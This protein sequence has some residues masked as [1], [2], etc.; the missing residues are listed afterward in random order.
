MLYRIKVK[1]IVLGNAPLFLIFTSSTGRFIFPFL[2]Q[3]AKSFVVWLLYCTLVQ[4]LHVLYENLISYSAEPLCCGLG[5]PWCWKEIMLKSILVEVN[6]WSFRTDGSG[7]QTLSSV[8]ANIGQG[9]VD[10][11]PTAPFM[12]K[13][14]RHSSTMFGH[15][16]VCN[17]GPWNLIGNSNK[18]FHWCVLS[19]GTFVIYERCSHFWLFH[20]SLLSFY[21][22][23]IHF[24]VYCYLRNRALRV[25]DESH[26][27]SLC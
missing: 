27:S 15:K 18:K 20:F 24:Y 11:K 14:L 13:F 19:K 2:S 6:H 10:L 16:L 7:R 12:L 4:L 26:W 3:T 21:G 9:T 23:A 17:F 8:V 1:L 25:S 22:W 5:Q